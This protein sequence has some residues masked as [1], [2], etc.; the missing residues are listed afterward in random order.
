MYYE[1][2][3]TNARWGE[4]R[5]FLIDKEIFY[6]NFAAYR[7]ECY[8]QYFLLEHCEINL[9]AYLTRKFCLRKTCVLDFANKPFIGFF[10]K[11]RPLVA[12]YQY[13]SCIL[14]SSVAFFSIWAIF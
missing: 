12:E 1:R 5:N 10:F 4:E 2:Y 7:N 14:I 13:S 6:S 3:N 9:K 8:V 11:S